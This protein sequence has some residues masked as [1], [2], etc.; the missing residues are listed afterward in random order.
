MFLAI[1]SHQYIDMN[2]YY[3]SFIL[4]HTP[5]SKMVCVSIKIN[6]HLACTN[7]LVEIKAKMQEIQQQMVKAKNE[8]AN[9]LKQAKSLGLLQRCFKAS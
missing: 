5:V 8:R 6:L 9:I 3:C 4:F 2:Y 1:L 7:K